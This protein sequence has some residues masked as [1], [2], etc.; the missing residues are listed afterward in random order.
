MLRICEKSYVLSSPMIK[1]SGLGSKTV[2]SD[3]VASFTYFPD[4]MFQQSTSLGKSIVGP[5]IDML[6]FKVNPILKTNNAERQSHV[7]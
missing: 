6:L 1:R 2:I 3:K 5:N 7:M 4:E